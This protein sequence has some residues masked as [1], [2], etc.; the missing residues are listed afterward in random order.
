MSH[1]DEALKRSLENRSERIGSCIN[2][3][4]WDKYEQNKILDLQR[5]NRCMNSRFCPNC[6]V[7]ENSK[8]IHKITPIYEDYLKQ[9]YYFYF[10]TLTV[11]SVKTLD[12]VELDSFVTQLYKDSRRFNQCFTSELKKE[13]F[14]NRFIKFAGGIR[15]LEITHNYQAGFHPHLHYIIITDHK[16][17]DE[18]LKPKYK[19][20]Y[21]RKRKQ[22]DYKSEFEAQIAKVWSLIRAG[23]FSTYNYNNYEYKPNE[24]YA[25]LN[26]EL[27]DF[28]NLEVDFREMDPEGFKEVFKYTV[29]SSEINSYNIFKCLVHTL[30]RRRV[31]QGFGI[32][33]NLK[34]DDCIEDVGEGQDL[35]LSIAE[36]PEVNL[37]TSLNDLFTVYS[38][39]KKISRFQPEKIDLSIED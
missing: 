30:Y 20:K 22:I 28:K 13:K 35:Q 31:R 1:E 36:D 26:G 39:Y 15:V 29:K 4:I 6:K 17:D 10:L 14:D 37:I 19:A 2:F 33:Y 8:F 11:P 34:I 9:G 18:L 23:K 3:W 25:T 32:L 27:Q 7:L 24:E 38:K 5:V 12:P 16:I 21:S